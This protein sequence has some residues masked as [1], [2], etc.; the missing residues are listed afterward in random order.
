MF[1]EFLSN[2]NIPS[3]NAEF[4]LFLALFTSDLNVLKQALSLCCVLVPKSIFEFRLKPVI[5]TMN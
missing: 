5:E 2:W 4:L 3:L 1:K